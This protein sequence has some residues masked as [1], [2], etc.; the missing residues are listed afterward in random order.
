MTPTKTPH[1]DWPTILGDAATI[2]TSYPYLITLRQLHY[3][4]VAT[5]VGGYRNDETSYKGLSARTAEARRRGTFPAL[6]DQTREIHRLLSWDD[7]AAAMTWLADQY[8]V[9]RT[10]GQDWLI[11]LG[12][13][14][15][16]LLAQLSDWFDDLDCPVVLVRGYGSQTYVDDVYDYV[17]ADKRRHDRQ[18]VLI[19]A[20]DLDP[21][22]EDILRDF[23]DR[24]PVFDKVEH[25][26]VVPSQIASLGLTVMPGK[27]TDSRAAGF[28][29]KHG[30]LMQIEV[31]AI[32]PATLRDLYQDA[33]DRY[34]DESVY[35][36]AVA[37][38]TA[39]ARRLRTIAD[40]FT[41]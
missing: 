5:G 3:R 34:W 30:R 12:G 8:R 27:A 28:V 40:G 25:I 26:A 37:T 16:T 23:L 10:I 14:K 4:L 39:D 38:E 13:E 7:P 33:I 36:T 22:G 32:P 21:S 20:G 15:A 41:P 24:C 35:D 11:V 18:A 2:V 19:Y 31:E 1:R 6:L 17:S 29:A 9:D